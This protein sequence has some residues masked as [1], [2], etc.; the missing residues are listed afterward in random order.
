[1]G[2]KCASKLVLGTAQL[3]MQYGIANRHGQ[4]DIDVARG[5]VKTAWS[6]GVREFDTA[7]AYGTSETVLGSVFRELGIGDEAR[8][9]SKIASDVDPLQLNELRASVE[10]T[11]ERLSIP[12]LHSLLLHEEEWLDL[13][14]RGLGE[15]LASL[16]AEGLVESFGVSV[17]APEAAF[18]ALGMEQMQSVQL[19]CNVFDRRFEDAGVFRE[20]ERVGKSLA[21]RSVFLQGLLLLDPNVVPSGIPEGDEH[22]SRFAQLADQHEISR[23]VLALSYV[24]SRY[25]NCRV[26]FGAETVEQVE[27]NLSVC[28]RGIPEQLLRE[29]GDGFRNVPERVVNPS[30]WSV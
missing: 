14:D 28:G 9:V 29:L 25:P 20:A 5:I 15:N 10:R 27:E 6:G 1:M 4:P 11:L 22:V 19:P 7:Q 17:Y 30:L 3:G 16:C 13:V 21:I 8:V 12:R 2:A 23:L 26:L 24:L 18:R